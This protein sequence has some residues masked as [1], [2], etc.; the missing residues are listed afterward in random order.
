M[1]PH[2]H[3]TYLSTLKICRVELYTEQ[4]DASSH[5][6]SLL[7]TDLLSLL[8]IALVNVL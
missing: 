7:F 8:L 6:L 2:V 3:P 4:F 1:Q 5:L